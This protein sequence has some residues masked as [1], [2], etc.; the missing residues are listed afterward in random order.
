MGIS[1]APKVLLNSNSDRVKN[2]VR[3]GLNVEAGQQNL[4]LKNMD[5]WRRVE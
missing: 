5:E 4:I 3:N 2:E 1:L